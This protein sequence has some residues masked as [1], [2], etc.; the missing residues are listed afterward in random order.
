MG[1]LNDKRG[2]EM[3]RAYHM[4]SEGR[5]VQGRHSRS[6]QLRGCSLGWAGPVD[7]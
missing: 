4:P 1:A 3:E 2:L 6:L 5:K 7:L